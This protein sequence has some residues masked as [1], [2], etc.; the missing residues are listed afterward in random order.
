MDA[1]HQV[2]AAK[3]PKKS[4]VWDRLDK[5]LKAGEG[6]EDDA[7]AAMEQDKTAVGVALSFFDDLSSADL[8]LLSHVWVADGHALA[9]DF[10]N[11]LAVASGQIWDHRLRKMYK[12]RS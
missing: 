4:T 2:V 9:E 10:A 3:K 7:S 6:R 8:F 1:K 5:R 11:D 12:V